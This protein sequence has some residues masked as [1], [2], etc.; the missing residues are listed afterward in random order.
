MTL[1]QENQ[2]RDAAPQR[3][4]RGR[5]VPAEGDGGVFSETWFPVRLSS[6]VPARGVHGCD[7]LDG[8]VVV[9]RDRHGEI[10]VFGAYCLHVG[11]DLSIGQVTDSG[12]IRCAFHGWEYDGGSGRCAYLPSG[13]P[14]P[15][16]ASLYRFP[17]VERYGIVFAFNGLEPRFSIPDFDHPEDSLVLRSG[18]FPDRFSVDSWVSRFMGHLREHP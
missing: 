10:R 18:T 11:A 16:R 2:V 1:H 4:L 13:D 6:D 3:R 17:A 5:A 12:N 9:S 15:P 7:F 14:V 8:R